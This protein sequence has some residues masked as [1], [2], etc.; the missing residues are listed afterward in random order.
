MSEEEIQEDVSEEVSDNSVLAEPPETTAEPVEAPVAE[1]AQ[2]VWN[3]FRQME[4]FQGQ[5]DTAIA[6]S[7]YEAMQ[8]EEHANRALQQY[9]TVVPIAQ[10]YLQNREQFEAW[11]ASQ[12]QT[13]QQPQQ[14]A[15]SQQPAQPA[16]KAWWSPPDVKESHKRYIVKDEN[17]RDTIHPDAPLDAKASLEEYMNFRADFAQK[18][19]DNPQEALGPMVEKMAIQQAETLIDQRMGRMKD[20]QY[21]SGLETENK[22]W[23]YDEKGNVSAEGMAVQKY[24]ADAKGHGIAGAEARWD[25]ATKM[26]ERDLLLQAVNKMQQ[27]QQQVAPQQVMQQAPQQAQ[28]TADQRNMDYLRQ[29]AARTPSQRSTGGTNA[30]EQDTTGMT[31]A[32][33][34]QAVAQEQGYL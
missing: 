31:F 23:L 22:D 20:E 33:K 26:V 25:Y 29:Q 34:L 28:P 14:A 12:F 18:F 9:Q 7:L 3:N 6:Q 24:I 8:R 2:D 11:K 5:E 19:L 13:Q 32:E 17:G 21:V 1:Q 30:A 27:P 4:Q 16:E 10:E 15:V